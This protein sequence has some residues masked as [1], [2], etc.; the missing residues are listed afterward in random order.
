MEIWHYYVLIVVGAF[1]SGLVLGGFWGGVVSAKRAF[2]KS[3]DDNG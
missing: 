1:A 3:M 2:K